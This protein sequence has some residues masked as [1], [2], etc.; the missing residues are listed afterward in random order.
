MRLHRRSFPLVIAAPSGAGKTSLARALVERNDALVFSIS[1]TTRAPRAGEANGRDYLFVADAVFDRMVR[2]GELLE[3]AVVHGQRY[4]TPR[5]AVEAAIDAGRV[6]V[7]DIDVQ[8]ARQVRGTF[9][10]AVLVFVLPPRTGEL[11]R[12]LAERGSEAGE[13][14]RIRLETAL[15]ELGAT[16][17]FE[18]VVVNDDFDAA[19]AGIEAIVGAERLRRTRAEGLTE[20]LGELE[21]EIRTVLK[22][23]D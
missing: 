1:A 15:L 10:E 7:L 20:I 23:G 19:L 21:E 9:P 3:W 6:V 16:P 8:G 17:E 5:S 22:R 4:G 14:R 13:A 2:D 18:Y 12:R 11:L